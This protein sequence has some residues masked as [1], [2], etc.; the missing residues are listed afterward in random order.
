MEFGEKV[1]SLRRKKGLTQEEL[2]QALNV[3]R[4]TVWRWENKRAN[5]DKNTMIL[6]AAALD[7]T[8][9]YLLGETDNPERTDPRHPLRDLPASDVQLINTIRVPVISGV[10]KACC[11][12]GNSYANDVE[13]EEAGFIDVPSRDL[14]GYTW[15]VG[16]D[17]FRTMNVE[18]NSMEPRIHDGDLILF[19]KLPYNNGNFVI[20]KYDDRLLVRAIWDDH[21]GHIRLHALNSAYKDIEVDLE[22]ESREFVI[23]GKVLR[24]ISME[25]LADGVM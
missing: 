3:Q 21:R 11:G 2:S 14:S 4:N 25:N 23:L 24:R 15:Q 16:N 1:R 20:V 17:G 6:L 19:A 8:I 22:D 13:W 10:V 5:P 12:N 7:T 9:A 18:G